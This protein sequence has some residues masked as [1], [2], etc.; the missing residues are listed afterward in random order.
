[1]RAR[2]IYILGELLSIERY[3]RKAVKGR[4][5]S[6][7]FSIG[8]RLLSKYW[9]INSSH[10]LAAVLQWAKLPFQ[11]ETCVL[12]LHL[13]VFERWCILTC[14]CCVYVFPLAAKQAA[15]VTMCKSPRFYL[16][17]G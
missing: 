17:F 7:L 2:C 15:Q 14:F 13:L 16:V 9:P 11:K 6:A 1:M 8:D 3:S 4:L 12:Q 10:S 5:K